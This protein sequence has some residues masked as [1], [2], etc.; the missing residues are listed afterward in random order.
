MRIA[1]AARLLGVSTTTLYNDAKAGASGITVRDGSY[2]VNFPLYNQWRQQQ[3]MRSVQA[4]PPETAEVSPTLTP[5][6]RPA[7]ADV[8]TFNGKTVAHV[9]LEREVLDLER[10]KLEHQKES[11]SLID[12]AAVRAAWVKGLTELGTTLEEA[13]HIA[14][15]SVREQFKLTATQGAELAQAIR[16]AIQTT[17]DRFSKLDGGTP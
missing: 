1:Q 11:G 5:A 7:S 13:P 8:P 3:A 17:L 6:G 15:E 16:A 4:P 14:V 12:A 10:E 9:R 2:H